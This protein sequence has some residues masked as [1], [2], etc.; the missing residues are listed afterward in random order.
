MR[1]P[2]RWPP[3]TAE[4]TE[5]LLGS[6]AGRLP[7]PA[8]AHP[9][10]SL[11]TTHPGGALTG[12]GTHGSAGGG[13]WQRHL[14]AGVVGGGGVRGRHGHHHGHP[15]RRRQ[16]TRTRPSPCVLHLPRGSPWFLSIAH[17]CGTPIGAHGRSYTPV[18]HRSSPPGTPRRRAA[19]PPP[20][21][22]APRTPPRG[23]LDAPSASPKML[24]DPFPCLTCVGHAWVGLGA[25]NGAL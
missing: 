1:A 12:L 14:V 25:Y 23:H 13:R 6:T 7:R 3:P 22:T 20:P 4:A 21:P 11:S 2:P 8:T 15:H 5:T 9:G 24:W 19:A 17:T 16:N 18:V 10:P